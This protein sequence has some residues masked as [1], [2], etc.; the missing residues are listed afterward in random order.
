MKE[1]T[2]GKNTKTLKK[3]PGWGGEHLAAGGGKIS[4]N[5]PWIPKM[6]K[7]ALVKW[8]TSWWLNQPS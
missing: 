2:V 3:P 4:L 1:K 6:E 8:S 7:I 5:G